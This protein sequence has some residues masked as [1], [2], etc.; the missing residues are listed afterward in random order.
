M[1]FAIDVFI[2]SFFELFFL[3]FPGIILI[4]FIKMKIRTKSNILYASTPIFSIGINYFCVWTLNKIG[5]FLPWKFVALIYIFSAL[6]FIYIQRKNLRFKVSQNSIFICLTL[7][8]VYLVNLFAWWRGLSNFSWLAPNADGFAHNLYAARMLFE[9]SVLNKDVFVQSPLIHNASEFSYFY[10]YPL[11]WHAHVALLSG[12]T[13][14]TIP[15]VTLTSSIFI[16]PVCA[17][18]GIYAVSKK[19]FDNW[20]AI[21]ALG[22]FAAVTV[23]IFPGVP[24]SWG[25]MPSVIGIALLFP[26]VALALEESEHKKEFTLNLIVL[27]F[28]CIFLFFIHSSEAVTSIIFVA[29]TIFIKFFR[30]NQFLGKYK[31][32]LILFAFICISLFLKSKTFIST[33]I[34]EQSSDLK[35]QL[36][37]ADRGFNETLGSLFTLSIRVPRTQIMFGILA[38][39]GFMLIVKK[40]KNLIFNFFIFETF[41]IY[42]LS[43]AN[44]FPLEKLRILTIPWYGSYERTAWTLVPLMCL[45]VALGIVEVFL[46][47]VKDK[48]MSGFSLGL[49]ALII[50][51]FQFQYGLKDSIAQFRLGAT[52]NQIAGVGSG[53]LFD[54][55][56]REY[57]KESI[58]L[59]EKGD[60]STYGYM[61]ENLNVTNGPFDRSGMYSD[62]ISRILETMNVCES[63]SRKLIM[64]NNL[65]GVI[66]GTRRFAWEAPRWT[67]ESI[68]KLKGFEFIE[69]S[70]DLFAL[71]IDFEKC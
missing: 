6:I 59:N 42:I 37:G 17:S 61:Y 19:L 32:K 15:F 8:L 68:S 28:S 22:S 63:S 58:W 23:P 25:A 47:K 21:G 46:S 16:W 54:R 1:N 18:I 36:G 11:A 38:L 52:E 71:K 49:A 43:G 66:L 5:I 67:E 20:L 2:F 50:F 33:A 56:K 14:L 4:Y 34:S 3:V 24:M 44:T 53:K 9:N 30:Q 64:E 13:N 45:L 41:V 48:T 35:S 40:S 29:A 65:A 51:I 55:L 31:H 70:S 12:A 62:G 69:R 10:F 57:P 27:I 39:V 26:I 60:G 7:V